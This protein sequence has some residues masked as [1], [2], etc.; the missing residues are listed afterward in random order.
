MRRIIAELIAVRQ[1]FGVLRSVREPLR[2]SRGV[3]VKPGSCANLRS[4]RERGFMDV[5]LIFARFAG[6]F[7]VESLHGRE[8]RFKPLAHPERVLGLGFVW[9]AL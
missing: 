5:V 4:L 6:W 1:A 9:K 7:D 8:V 2:R 3:P